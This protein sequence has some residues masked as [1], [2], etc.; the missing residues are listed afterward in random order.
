L[1]N[2]ISVRSRQVTVSHRATKRMR[3]SPSADRAARDA[4]ARTCAM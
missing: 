3:V 1:K 4:L 2:T